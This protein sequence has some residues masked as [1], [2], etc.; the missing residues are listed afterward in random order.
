MR[1]SQSKRLQPEASASDPTI[2]PDREHTVG[3]F[4]RGI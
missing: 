3:T 1:V 4:V 2:Q